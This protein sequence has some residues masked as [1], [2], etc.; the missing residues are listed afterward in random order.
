MRN[1]LRHGLLFTSPA[2]LYFGVFWI[3]PLALAV[4]YSFTNWVVGGPVDFVGLANYA[5]LLG[6]PLFRQSV[7]ASTYITVLTVAGSVLIAL[8]LAVLLN[9]EHLHGGR[10]FRILIILPVLTDWVATGLVWQ[11]IFLPNQ[12]VLADFLYGLGLRELMGLRWTSSR[13]L[14]PL[15]IVV[16]SI[17]KTTGLYAIIF[18]AALKSVPRQY[19]EAARV[20]GADAW[21]IFVNVTLPMIKPI[22][23]FI[24]VI[25]FVSAMGLFEPVFM[26]TGGGPADATRTLPLF[27]FETFFQFRSGGYAS[28]ASV[29][30]LAICLGFALVAARTLRYSHFE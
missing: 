12:G 22:S 10:L 23:V 19:L 2:F 21:Q 8:G 6:D 27:L 5:E 13:E 11:L 29:L 7:L 1:E 14:A 30:F 17:W 3:L 4:F 18:L 26:L 15:A 9:D 25:A 24:L 28:A 16:F 20:E